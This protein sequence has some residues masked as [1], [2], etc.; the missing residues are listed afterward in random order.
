MKLKTFCTIIIVALFIP[1]LS[2][3]QIFL[4]GGLSFFQSSQKEESSSSKSTYTEYEINPSFGYFVK[5]NVVFGIGLGIGGSKDD[6]NKTTSLS[7]GIFNRYY[8]NLA[9]GFKFYTHTRADVKWSNYYP[10]YGSDGNTTAFRLRVTP[11][12]SYAITPKMSLDFSVGYIGYT[13][14]KTKDAE[15]EETL[16]KNSSFGLN[17]N[18]I[19]FGLSFKL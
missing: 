6:F 13:S 8:F 1:S 12:V 3:S 18:S 16:E 5:D 19:S 14:S 9:E 11:G 17:V 2:F 7:A 10:E 15:T 4:G